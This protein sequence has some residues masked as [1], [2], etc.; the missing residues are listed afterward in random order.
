[1]VKE[2]FVD[3]SRT[4]E[5]GLRARPA[6]PRATRNPLTRLLTRRR[7]A[8][9]RRRGRGQPA[10]RRAPASGRWSASAVTTSRRTRLAARVRTRARPSC[11]PQRTRSRHRARCAAARA[12]G[13]PRRSRIGRVGACLAIVHRVRARRPRS[14]STCSR[15]EPARARPSQL[16]DH[17]RAA[18]VR[19]AP[20]HRPRSLA[21]PQ[22]VIQEAAAPRA[23]PAARAADLPRGAERAAAGDRRRLDRRHHRRLVEDEAEPWP[24]AAVTSAAARRRSAAARANRPRC[25][26]RARRAAVRH[27]GTPRTGAPRAAGAPS[28]AGTPAHHQTRPQARLGHAAPA[29]PARVLGIVLVV[30]VL[31]FAA[32]GVRL[33][34]LQ[35]RDRS[36]LSSLGARAAGAHRRHP[37]RARE[38]LRPHRQDP[39]GVGAAD[40]DRRRP[41]GDQGSDRVRGEAGADRAG[42]PGRT[43]ERARRTTRARSRTSPARSTT[44][45]PKQVRDLDLVGI[46]FQDESRRFY[47]VGTVAAPVV[48]FVGTDNNGLGGMEY[49]FDELLTGTPGSV[50]VERDPQGN[51]IPGGE[52][53][54]TAAKRG[55]DVV[56]TI[57]SSLQ[58]KTEQALLQGV[59]AMNA[60]GRHGD[61]RRRADRRRARDGDGRRRHR[62]RA[63]ARRDRDREQPPGHRRVRAGLDEQGDHDGGRD[64]GRRRHA[65]QRRST[66]SYQIDQRRRQADYEDVE[67][68]STDDDR[69]RDILAQSSNVGTI[70]IAHDARQGPPRATTSDAFG[71]G[72]RDRPRTFPARRRAASFDA[73]QYND[74]SMGSVPIG[75]GIAVTA[76]QMLDV[77]TTI[78]NHGMA[79]PPRLVDGDDRRRRQAPRR[80]AARRPT[81]WCRRRP[82]TR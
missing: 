6:C 12:R 59:V 34:D 61:R 26:A 27:R 48:G 49:H 20:P 76:M 51:D 58:W 57:D 68:H 11:S 8:A 53:Q 71:F 69:R 28:G 72:Q 17:D 14:C 42:R 18:H 45:P 62:H 40:D 9:D 21:S 7:G 50:Q 75:Y 63:R 38:H 56:L 43:R 52:R 33:F 81:R 30:T 29:D 1:M 73:S 35:A 67:E 22:R 16:A 80:A 10:C 19:A 31:A 13:R 79:R 65:G 54:V 32:I 3:W 74:T 78:A 82:P 15:A 55:Q 4:E 23:R 5:P 2:R 36:H 77:Y 66:T 24:P 64:P 70:K 46:S 25:R 44:R 37:R 39:R 47:P 41:A 60:Q